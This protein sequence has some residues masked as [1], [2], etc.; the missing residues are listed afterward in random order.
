MRQVYDQETFILGNTFFSANG[1]NLEPFVICAV[2]W[3]TITERHCT[4]W[5]PR[6]GVLSQLLHQ[7]TT[8]TISYW[9]TDKNKGFGFIKYFALYLPVGFTLLLV[10]GVSQHCIG[11]FSSLC[12]S[13]CQAASSERKWRDGHDT[14][15]NLPIQQQV[16]ACLYRLKISNSLLRWV[17]KYCIYNVC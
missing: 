1:I 16:C 4:G 2:L 6:P 11:T 9:S 12:R 5:S 14:C 8:S 3:H 7:N 13:C 10:H 17:L 15:V